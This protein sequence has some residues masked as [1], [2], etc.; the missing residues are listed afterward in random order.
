MK[1]IN[2]HERTGFLEN[3]VKKQLLHDTDHARFVLFCLEPGQ[4]IEPHTSSSTVT[5]FVVEGKGQW[6]GSQELDFKRG[7]VCFYEPEEPH[8]FRAEERTVLLAAIT[9]SPR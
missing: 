5:I 2:I 4:E 3:D 1:T 7:D 9:P 8:G 6:L